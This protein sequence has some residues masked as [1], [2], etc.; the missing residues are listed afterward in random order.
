MKTF[1][2]LS[3]GSC[4]LKSHK[5]QSK[6]IEV[7]GHL[8]LQYLWNTRYLENVCNFFVKYKNIQAANGKVGVPLPLYK[9]YSFPFLLYLDEQATC[10]GTALVYISE[11]T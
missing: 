8:V 3:P 2:G 7:W 10:S 6:L 11:C 9:L 1:P 4:P 5:V